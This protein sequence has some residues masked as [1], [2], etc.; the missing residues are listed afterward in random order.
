MLRFI[1]FTPYPRLSAPPL[2]R[3]F[4]PMRQNDIMS[5]EEPLKGI[6]KNPEAIIAQNPG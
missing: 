3:A 5:A 6:S 2:Q 4:Q 1:G